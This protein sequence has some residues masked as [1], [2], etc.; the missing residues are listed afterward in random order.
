[1]R[2]IWKYSLRGHGGHGGMVTMPAGARILSVKSLGG[3]PVVYAL[4][5]PAEPEIVKHYF[6]LIGTGQNVEMEPGV[7]LGTVECEPFMWH[8]FVEYNQ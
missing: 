5:D 3:V 4:V 8:I 1:M 7:Y 2:V 6:H